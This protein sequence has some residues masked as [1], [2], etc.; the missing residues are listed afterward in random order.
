MHNKG[1]TLIELVATLIVLS[2]VALIV[3]PNIYN[4]VKDYRQQ[5]YE[6]QLVSIET[7]T[8]NWVADHIG[9]ENFPKE[10]NETLF[11]YLDDLQKLSG[12]PI[13]TFF[14][15]EKV[16][17]SVLTSGA[18]SHRENYHFQHKLYDLHV[19]PI[20]QNE[21]I[22]VTIT[23]ITNLHDSKE[24]VAQKAREVINK[25]ISTVQQI[26]CLLGEHMVETE[27]LLN[28][29]ADDYDEGDE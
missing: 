27:T 1:F 9:D 17:T 26:A 29:I 20:E 18:E 15:A 25:N 3:V 11:V 6:T 12:F 10:N 21:S 4:N 24:M 23:D 13:S 7:A 28:E 19:F 14:D 8:K 2:M 16:F 22:G 5:L